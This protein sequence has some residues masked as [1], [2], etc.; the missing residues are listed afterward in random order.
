MILID[1]HAFGNIMLIMDFGIKIINLY[2][3]QLKRADETQNNRQLDQS[4]L[5]RR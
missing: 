4:S 2:S 3:L 1:L 5:L